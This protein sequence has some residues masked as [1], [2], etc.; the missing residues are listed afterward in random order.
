MAKNLLAVGL[1]GTFAAASAFTALPSIRSEFL[2][3]FFAN[4]MC[5]RMLCAVSCVAE[6]DV[7]AGGL[8]TGSFQFLPFFI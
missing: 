3:L 7:H 4:K 1:L 2:A 6:H 8:M 5:M